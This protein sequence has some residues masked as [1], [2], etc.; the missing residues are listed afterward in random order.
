MCTVTFI[1]SKHSFF[2][3]H[4]RDE[5]IV[6]KKALYPRRYKIND[7]NLLYPKD[8][9]AGGTW[10]AINDNGNT[11]VLLNGAFSPHIPVPPYRQSRGLVLLDI[12]ASHD[13]LRTWRSISLNNI[14]PF[15][16]ILFNNEKLV[17]TRWD[18]KQKH[19]LPLNHQEKHI[20]SSSTLYDLETLS[21]RRN[22]FNRWS[23]Q[24]P[25]PVINDILQFHLDGGE[26]DINNDI[27]MNRDGCLLTVSI[28]AMELNAEKGIMKY[29]DLEDKSVHHQ[30]I[31]FVKN[32][33][34]N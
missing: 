26:G 28:T 13:M 20:W 24:H 34:E 8:A 27:Q 31:D 30:E 14:E 18:G 10:M 17:E 7:F 32:A 21:K 11:V 9:Q 4:S 29:L 12:I 2:L 23:Q 3:T 19:T 15:T 5:S 33:V 1:P 22:W 6:R 16:T 25:R